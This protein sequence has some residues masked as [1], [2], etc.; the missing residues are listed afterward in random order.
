MKRLVLATGN[1][2]KAREIEHVFRPLG[3]EVVPVT[4]LV[5]SW[6][7]QESADSLV[8]NALLKARAAVSLTHGTAIADDTGLFVDALEGAPGVLSSRYAGPGATYPDNVRA[9]LEALSGIPEAD[10]MARF[11]TAVAL[12]R[13][14]GGERTFTGELE[15]RILAAP[16]GTGGFGYDPVFLVPGENK[17]LA[18]ISLAQKNAISHRARAFRAAA[19]FLSEHPDWLAD[20]GTTV[21]PRD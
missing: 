15:G 17:T 6:S 14:G 9:L 4:A 7:V 5:S 18:E 12:V 10:G 11:R 8:E 16:R 2:D 1:P 3:I 21:G 20:R 13:P 19:A